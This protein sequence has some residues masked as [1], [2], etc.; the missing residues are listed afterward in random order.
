ME[1][2]LLNEIEEKLKESLFPELKIIN[3]SPVS[4]GCINNGCKIETSEGSFFLK[5]NDDRFPG[6][7]EKEAAGLAL[8]N[9]TGT[10]RVP[11]VIFT[12]KTGSEKIFILLEWISSS[13]KKSAFSDTFG[14]QLA[15]LHSHTRDSF[16]L[17]HDNYIGSLPQYNDSRAGWTEFF[18]EQRLIPQVKMTRDAR[19]LPGDVV[20]KME[21]LYQRLEDL[22]PPEKPALLHGD[23]WGGNFMADENGEPAIFDPAVYFGHRE[24]ELAFTKLF[25]GFDKDFYTSY[26][27]SFP[28]EKGFE[29]RVDIYNLYPL[30]VHVNLFGES[31]LFQVQQILKR[32][33]R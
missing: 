22:F 31:Y 1:G 33:V 4:G 7:F 26:N 20:R 11:E 17:D 3:S 5:Y 13:T 32:F 25:G 10:P 12:G 29:E 30:L 16:G 18:I 19:G 23:L 9:K 14:R 27:N 28:L 15:K 21:K 24:M 6:M 2:Q 8:L